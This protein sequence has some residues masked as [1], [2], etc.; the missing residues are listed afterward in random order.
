MAC[1]CRLV[2]P[3]HVAMKVRPVH[4]IMRSN[5]AGTLQADSRSTSSACSIPSFKL[6]CHMLFP[7]VMASSELSGYTTA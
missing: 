1:I 5:M 4:S 6:R 7:A 2:K 3:R